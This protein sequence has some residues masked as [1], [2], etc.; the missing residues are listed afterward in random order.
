MDNTLCHNCND[1]CYMTSFMT[2]CKHQKEL[3]EMCLNKT[4]KGCMKYKEWYYLENGHCLNYTNWI[5]CT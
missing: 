1:N 2:L 4:D 3:G 5:K